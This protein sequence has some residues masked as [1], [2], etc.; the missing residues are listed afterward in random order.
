MISQHPVSLIL[1]GHGIKATVAS[2]FLGPDGCLV[3]NYAMS[4]WVWILSTL[5][6]VIYA[7]I[8]SV[9]LSVISF[10]FLMTVSDS[11]CI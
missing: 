3:V 7:V 9:T 8:T 10:S 2:W 1:M 4:Q 5:T 6:L 11:L